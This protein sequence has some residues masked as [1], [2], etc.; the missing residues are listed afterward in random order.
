MAQPAREMPTFPQEN[1]QNGQ[2]AG[3]NGQNEQN[4]Q[5]GQNGHFAVYRPLRGL[6][7]PQ[8]ADSLF[9][10]VM[11]MFVNPFLDENGGLWPLPNQP[12]Q[13]FTGWLLFFTTL[14]LRIVMVTFYQFTNFVLK[15]ISPDHRPG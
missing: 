7:R 9:Q 4:E 6:G 12:P 11:T 10:R 8:P 2:N 14:P 5:N 3:Q 13:G 15:L 1:G